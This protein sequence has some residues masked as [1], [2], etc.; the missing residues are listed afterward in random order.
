MP[1]DT[2]LGGR[3]RSVNRQRRSR[4]DGRRLWRRWG[5]PLGGL[6][7]AMV[8]IMLAPRWG[9][10]TTAKAALWS[11][12][13]VAA[14]PAANEGW[15]QLARELK[16]AV[17]NISTKRAAAAPEAMSP[18]G[19]DERLNEFFKHYFG[20]QPRRPARSLGSGFVINPD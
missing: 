18:F 13:P 8:V 20:N 10:T 6:V 2:A 15:V 1:G 19:G 9:F 4:M 14:A 17:V 5:W 16:P 11:E 7:V 12:R 3:R